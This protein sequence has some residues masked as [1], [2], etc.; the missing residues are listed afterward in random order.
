MSVSVTRQLLDEISKDEELY[1]EL[2]KKI[3]LAIIKN[4]E[5]RKMFVESILNEIRSEEE[6]NVAK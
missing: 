6:K 5:I 3:V 2:V 4:E 1:N